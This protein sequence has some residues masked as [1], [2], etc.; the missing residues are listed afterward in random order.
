MSHH[1]VSSDLALC[2]C[3]MLSTRYTSSFHWYLSLPYICVLHWQLQ[4]VSPKLPFAVDCVS[5]SVATA[6]LFPVHAGTL[7]EYVH[8]TLRMHATHLF[9]VYP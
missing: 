1:A 9:G 6:V 2:I 7:E 8:Y 3:V 5:G 4:I